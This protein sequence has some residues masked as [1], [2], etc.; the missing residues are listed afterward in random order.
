MVAQKTVGA[1]LT[2]A[3]NVEDQLEYA[4]AYKKG[5]GYVIHQVS[6][7]DTLDGI[8]IRYNVSKDLIRR[9]N[10]FTGDEIFMKKELVIP[11]AGKSHA[12]NLFRWSNLQS[13]S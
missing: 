8:S 5:V 1:K 2:K 6:Q 13:V 12:S 10:Q 11:D 7:N 3:E 4:P 9:A